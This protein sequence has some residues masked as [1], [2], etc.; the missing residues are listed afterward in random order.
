MMNATLA[1][2]KEMTNPDGVTQPK[3]N[4]DD[5]ADFIMNNEELIMNNAL[6]AQALF[7]ISYSLSKLFHVK[8]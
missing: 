8:H 4:N 3:P 6:R 2:P 7:I 5:D 1:K